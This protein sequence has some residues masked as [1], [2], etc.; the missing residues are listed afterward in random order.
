MRYKRGYRD[1]KRR[2]GTCRWLKRYQAKRTC[3]REEIEKLKD[4][5]VDELMSAIFGEEEENS[6]RVVK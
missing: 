6:M 2:T 3:R 4:S 5:A 1:Q